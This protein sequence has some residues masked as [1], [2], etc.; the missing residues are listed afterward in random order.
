MF[1][2]EC[3]SEYRPGFTACSDCGVDLVDQ[4]VDIFP[5]HGAPQPPSPDSRYDDPFLSTPDPQYFGAILDILDQAHIPYEQETR[6]S[7]ALAGLSGKRFLLFVEPRREEEAREAV[8]RFQ[9]QFAIAAEDDDDAPLPDDVVSADFD[10][11]EATVEV[12]H[13]DDTGLHNTLVECLTNVG[14]GCATHFEDA[15]ESNNAPATAAAKPNPIFVLPS[16]EKRAREVIREIVNA[17]PPE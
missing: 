8:R 17:S 9:E 16:D 10:P 5:E 7:A 6:D 14:I 13:G 2:P 12:W 3:H 11:D 15:A 4:L 1:C